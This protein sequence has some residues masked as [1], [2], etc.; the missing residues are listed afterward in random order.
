MNRLKNL[1]DQ[2]RAWLGVFEGFENSGMVNFY[3]EKLLYFALN[4][5]F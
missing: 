2:T 4:Q 3:E 5:A 1:R